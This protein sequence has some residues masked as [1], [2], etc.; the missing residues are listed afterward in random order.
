M[1]RPGPTSEPPISSVTG[2][3]RILV[4]EPDPAAAEMTVL[5]LSAAG[6]D[7]LRS[8]THP[9]AIATVRRWH[10]DLVLLDLLPTAYS[11]AEVAGLLARYAPTPTMVVST[12]TDIDL[13]DLTLNAGASEYLTKPFRVDEL[14]HRVHTNL[15]YDTTSTESASL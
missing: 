12:D 14:V 1:Q 4:V 3:A 11:P 15:Q 5:V 8:H 13:I 7:T 6:F 2:P 9:D 10:P